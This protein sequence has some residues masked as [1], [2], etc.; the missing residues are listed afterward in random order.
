[1]E[2]ARKKAWEVAKKTA[3]D[4]ANLK[5][6]GEADARSVLSTGNKYKAGYKNRIEVLR[7]N[8]QGGENKSR[9]GNPYTTKGK[10]NQKGYDDLFI[11]WQGDMAK[12]TT[13]DLDLGVKGAK[14]DPGKNWS[15]YF[16]TNKNLESDTD[17]QRRIHGLINFEPLDEKF[18]YP[19]RDADFYNSNDADAV[20]L[21]SKPLGLTVALTLTLK[22]I[23]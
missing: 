10:T 5:A 21:Y 17:L 3:K 23:L 14:S 12:M 20:M 18:P 13:E 2:E 8:G 6:R 9:N 15:H 4:N 19:V 7:L 1:M 11:D 16:E 22:A